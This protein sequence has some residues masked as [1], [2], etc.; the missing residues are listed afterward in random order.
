MPGSSLWLVPPPS[1]PLSH[2]LRE[3]I[4]STLPSHFPAETGAVTSPSTP[5]SL[6]PHFFPAHITLT[7]GI[8]PET[9]GDDDPQAWLDSIPW[10]E[11]KPKVRFSGIESQDVFYRRCFIKVELNEGVRKLAGLAR[12]RG[13][14]APQVGG[15]EGEVGKRVEEWLV[16]WE[17]AFGPHV[18]LM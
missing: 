14:I 15:D 5:T 18:S 6:S 1:S 4:T 17:K 3:L 2:I 11:E 13:V 12:A 7:S 9:Y 10:P 8:S 16:Q